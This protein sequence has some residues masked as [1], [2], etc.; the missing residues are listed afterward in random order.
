[1]DDTNISKLHNTL[2]DLN[3]EQDVDFFNRQADR[4]EK[5]TEK[6]TETPEAPAVSSSQTR[7]DWFENASYDGQLSVDVFQTPDSVVIQ[8]TIA[9]VKPDD[10]DI[11]IQSD[12][13][14]I[15]GKRS[16]TH[17]VQDENY[18]Y[19]ECYWGGFSR[20]IILPVEIRDD[21]AA[22]EMEDGILT[23]TL[24]KANKSKVTTLKVN[25]KES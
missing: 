16:R 9:G 25:H 8:S 3:N 2:R 18:L 24:P 14:T 15:R 6:Q 7:E 20:S 23:I 10:L 1:M 17:E 5:S 21:K 11:S 19:Q 22:A 13:V 12:M 4:A